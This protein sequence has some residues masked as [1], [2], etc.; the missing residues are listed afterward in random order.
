MIANNGHVFH[1]CDFFS[2]DLHGVA[3]AFCCYSA[4]AD[5]SLFSAAA[6]GNVKALKA[7]LSKGV[8]LESRDSSGFTP[9]ILAAK[10][11][12]VEAARILIAAGASALTKS[13]KGSPPLGFAAE[14]GNLEMIQLLVEHG[15]EIEAPGSNGAT[16]LT[17]AADRG[18][19]AALNYFLDHGASI[20]LPG[21][22][23]SQKHLVTPLWI[24]VIRGRID[25]VKVLLD[26]G[27]QIN[28]TTRN[29]NVVM[30][31]AKYSNPEMLRYLISRGA[32]IHQLAGGAGGRTALLYAAY[33]GREENVKILL[34][35]GARATKGILEEAR[36]EP[37]SAGYKMLEEAIAKGAPGPPPR[38]ARDVAGMPRNEPSADGKY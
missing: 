11:G 34:E 8:D 13:A 14:T 31:A 6:S 24:A 33:N 20:D 4:Q 2:R 32:N 1:P 16:P 18:H 30:E 5:E 37:G 26:R 38:T 35:A 7:T 36:F 22:K 21:L 28:K 19:L 3:D 15:A 29:D 23:D 10:N 17:S 12:R 27:A 9:L 25:V